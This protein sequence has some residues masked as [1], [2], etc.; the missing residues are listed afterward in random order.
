LA[1][2]TLGA[3][4]SKENALDPDEF[5]PEFGVTRRQLEAEVKRR[6]ASLDS[7]LGV[8]TE[9]LREELRER[10]KDRIQLKGRRQSSH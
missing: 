6:I 5:L 10:Q 2:K 3:N 4:M 7:G 9:Q 1:G 8:T